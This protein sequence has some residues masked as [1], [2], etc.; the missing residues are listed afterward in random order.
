MFSN[1]QDNTSQGWG[2]RLLEK[3]ILMLG[4]RWALYLSEGIRHV[5]KTLRFHSSP[6]LEG[7]EFLL[8][9]E[10]GQGRGDRG[11]ASAPLSLLHPGAQFPTS[12]ISLKPWWSM[13]P[14]RQVF[15]S[16]WGTSVLWVWFYS[17]FSRCSFRN[18]LSSQ[19]SIWK[20]YQ[21]CWQEPKRVLLGSAQASVHRSPSHLQWWV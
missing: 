17:V 6:V 11:G 1:L 7:G 20:H 19:K 4:R 16:G 2:S 8:R 12:L 15:F 14:S 9:V 5:R 3:V 13:C 18:C 10:T 21:R